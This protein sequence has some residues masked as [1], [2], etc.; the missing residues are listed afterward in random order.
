MIWRLKTKLV[1]SLQIIT[2]EG[3]KDQG[4]KQG[5]G[6]INGFMPSQIAATVAINWNFYAQR[7]KLRFKI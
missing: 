6:G 2:I 5:R 4:R 1:F 7:A 3:T